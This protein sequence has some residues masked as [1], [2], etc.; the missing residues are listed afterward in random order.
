MRPLPAV[1][2]PAPCRGFGTTRADAVPIE[3]ATTA[4]TH[5]V[6]VPEARRPSGHVTERD[7]GDR[8]R[9]LTQRSDDRQVDQ[10]IPGGGR[11]TVVS[12]TLREMRSPRRAESRWWRS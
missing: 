12:E 10:L 5:A 7:I 11:A 6:S 3:V 9:L 4:H 1:T 8:Q 2:Q